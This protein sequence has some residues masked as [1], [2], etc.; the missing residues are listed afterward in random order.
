MDDLDVRSALTEYVTEAEPPIG[1][2]EQGVLA[3]GRRSR[4][5]RL[6]AGITGAA[7]AVVAALGVTF[8]VIAP[9]PDG[10]VA[11]DRCGTKSP[12]ETA[13]QV[14]TRMSCTVGAAVRSRLAPGVRIE[15]LTLP[16]EIPPSDPFL[17]YSKQFPETA[18]ASTFYFL[19][20]RVSDDRGAGSV[21][22]RISPPL[23]YGMASCEAENIPKADSCTSRRIA[24]GIL[25]EL[26]SRTP[27]GLIVHTTMLSG[28]TATITLISN[29]SGVLDTGDGFRPPVQSAEPPLSGPQLQDIAVRPGLV[30]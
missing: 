27:E 18:A 30:P 9:Q 7:L 4:R 24:E 23:G 10:P 14:I 5:R 29:N 16:E 21:Y 28:P 11:G 3:A 17:L 25:L 19:G 20:V 8:A 13:Q 1:L 6:S 22:V 26:T 2:T 15:R 12:G